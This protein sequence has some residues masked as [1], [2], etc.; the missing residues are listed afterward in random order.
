MANRREPTAHGLTDRQW[1]EADER[2]A[3]EEDW[4]VLVADMEPP[5]DLSLNRPTTFHWRVGT[6]S[7][8][9]AFIR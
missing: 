4:R 7:I 6:G 9:R 2:A 3:L 5:D 1:Q 8:T